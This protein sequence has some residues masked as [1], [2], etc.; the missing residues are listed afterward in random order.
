MNGAAKCFV[1]ESNVEMT[2]ARKSLVMDSEDQLVK[3]APPPV[4]T[5]RQSTLS[6]EKNDPTPNQEEKV[7]LRLARQS[8][9]GDQF[10]RNI[11]QNKAALVC[12]VLSEYRQKTNA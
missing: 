12:Y 7:R 4:K 3:M 5:T 11:A 2:P 1:A 9:M 6:E 8:F 10:N